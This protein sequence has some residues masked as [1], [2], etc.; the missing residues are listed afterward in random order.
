VL[1]LPLGAPL[2]RTHGRKNWSCIFESSQYPDPAV[3]HCEHMNVVIIERSPSSF[4]SNVFKEVDYN[5]VAL[6]DELA[7]FKHLEVQDADHSFDKLGEPFLPCKLPAP[8]H[9][10]SGIG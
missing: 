4:R 10:P 1:H 7:N 6:R 5:F 8:G 9:A 3:A 2:C